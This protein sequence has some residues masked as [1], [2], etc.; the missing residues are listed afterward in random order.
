MYQC[1]HDFITATFL[2][3]SIFFFT[4]F[5]IT[6]TTNNTMLLS[7]RCAVLCLRFFF[8]LHFL[9]LAHRCRQAAIASLCPS[10]IFLLLFIAHS[11]LSRLSVSVLV[12]PIKS[13]SGFDNWRNLSSE[14]QHS[15]AHTYRQF[16]FPL[17]LCLPLIDFDPVVCTRTDSTAANA[18]HSNNPIDKI[19]Q[20]ISSSLN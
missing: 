5:I 19:F 4:Q 8:S 18:Q 10:S 14:A 6:T 17:I 2:L 1:A 15:T 11:L 20:P 16:K 3:C 9:P 7:F 13:S 12:F